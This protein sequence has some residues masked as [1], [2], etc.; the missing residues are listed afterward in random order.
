MILVVASGGGSE[1]YSSH[2][3]RMIEDITKY[4]GINF[5]DN[6]ICTGVDRRGDVKKRLEVLQKALNAGRSINVSE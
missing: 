6:I 2:I 1:L 4:V 5:K 3:V